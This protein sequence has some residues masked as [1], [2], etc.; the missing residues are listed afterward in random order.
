[1][2][3]SSYKI[4]QYPYILGNKNLGLRLKISYIFS[5]NQK[6]FSFISRNG[7]FLKK[8][9]YISGGNCWSSKTKRTF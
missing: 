9:S 5:K 8:N 3:L 7:N 2:E 4:K 1:M 6:S